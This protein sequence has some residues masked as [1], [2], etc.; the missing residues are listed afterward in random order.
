L[1]QAT[2]ITLGIE[3]GGQP[4][5]P[6][7]PIHVVLDV[8]LA[9]PH[10]LHRTV[11]ML[12]DLDRPSNTVRFQPA[13]EPVAD[14][15]V[16]DHDLVQRHI[17][18]LCGRGLDSRHGLG[19]DPDFARVAA[20]MDRAVHRLHGRMREERKVVGRVDLGRSAR[21]RLADVADILR[22]DPWFERRLFELCRDIT[23]LSLAWEPS[24]HSIARAS[25]PFFAA[26][27]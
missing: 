24:S 26:P 23:V 4:I 8:L 13:A 15:M 27:M 10:D 7:R 3:T 20:D 22:D 12:R 25:R 6:I 11:D 18:Y 1:F 16:V 21:H 19:A 5:E 17:H 9:R 14:Q 2:G